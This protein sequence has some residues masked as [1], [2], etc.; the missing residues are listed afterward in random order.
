MSTFE[1][2]NILK[3]GS[4]SSWDAFRTVNGLSGI[5]SLAIQKND[6]LCLIAR[7][8]HLFLVV[9]Q[10]QKGIGFVIIGWAIAL[11]GM[12]NIE[13]MRGTNLSTFSDLVR[14]R[15]VLMQLFTDI[16][17][18]SSYERIVSPLENEQLTS[19]GRFKILLGFN[20]NLS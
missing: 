7:F 15:N 6:I 12:E 1:V 5:A 16:G 2:K 20:K 18:H 17:N 19:L 11:V 3:S 10:V 14:S 4:T 8:Q 13:K 9:R